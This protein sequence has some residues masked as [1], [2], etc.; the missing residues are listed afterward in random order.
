[1]GDPLD[2]RAFEKYIL[3]AGAPQAGEGGGGRGLGGFVCGWGGRSMTFPPRAHLC[4]RHR[5]E[6]K[7]KEDDYCSW[8]ELG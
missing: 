7:K 6:L 5:T 2:E 1:M 3:P 4:L 8:T